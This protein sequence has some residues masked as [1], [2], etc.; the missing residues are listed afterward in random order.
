[1]HTLMRDMFGQPADHVTYEEAIEAGRIVRVRVRVVRSATRDVDYEIV[2]FGKTCSSCDDQRLKEDVPADKRCEC[3]GVYEPNPAPDAALNSKLYALADSTLEADP[4]RTA[5]IADIV[6]REHDAGHSILVMA[7]HIDHSQAIMDTVRERGVGIVFLRGGAKYK[8]ER[9]QNIEKLRHGDVRKLTD[10]REIIGGVVAKVPDAQVMSDLDASV[11]WAGESG[12]ADASR[13]AVTGFCWGGRI[14]WLY[15][16]HSAQLDAGVAW[17]GRLVGDTRPQTPK[18]PIELA[19][20]L[21][22]P[23]LGLYG[24]RDRGIPVASVEQMRAALA[25]HGKPGE[26]VVYDEAS[27]GFHADYRPSYDPKAAAD[28]WRRLLDWLRKNGV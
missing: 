15:A 25:Q 27:H 22:A 20:S 3:G 17:Y 7:R 16:A 13:V 14:V 28:G 23:V 11:Q 5:Q 12:E 19:G 21:R 2:K 24:G 18:H 8:K 9:Q 10:I 4:D 6:K 26:L 1:M